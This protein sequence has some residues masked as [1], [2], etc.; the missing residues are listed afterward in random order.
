MS[1]KLKLSTLSGKIEF[2]ILALGGKRDVD[3]AENNFYIEKF[4]STAKEVKDGLK[5]IRTK[6]GERMEKM[7]ISGYLSKERV[8]VDL[9]IKSLFDN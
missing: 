9:E 4:E 8:M 2:M 3:V 7:A 6:L 5:E 1:Q